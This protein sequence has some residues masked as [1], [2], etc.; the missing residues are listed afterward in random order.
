MA[1]ITTVVAEVIGFG[2]YALKS[3]K[4]NTEGGI[5]YETTMRELESQNNILNNNNN[6]DGS[7]G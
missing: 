2:V 7:V 5:I 3:A 4:E 6:D 1:L